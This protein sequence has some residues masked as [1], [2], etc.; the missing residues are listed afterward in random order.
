MQS[1]S[2]A[3]CILILLISTF[4]TV[5]ESAVPT[6]KVNLH[7]SAT[8][9]CYERCSGLVR[10]T[11]SHKPT[12]ALAEC[13]QTSCR[14]VKEGYQMIHD[15]YLKGNLSLIITDADFTKRNMYTCD[16]DGKDLCDVDLQIESLKTTVQIKPGESLVLD[17]EVSDPVEVIY[18]SSDGAKL[19]S[20]QI[21]KVDG[22]SLQCKDEYKQRMSIPST[23]EL[24]GI[25]PSDSG[26]YTIR[27]SRNEEVI[28]TYTVT[29]Q[30]DLPH[31]C[32]DEGTCVPAWTVVV[33]VLVGAGLVI[34]VVVIVRQRRESQRSSRPD[35]S[36]V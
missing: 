24:R 22:H 5:S 25:K 26:V 9:S 3:L 31:P 17:L 20:G 23:V 33:L 15:Q 29:V 16:C 13:D 6:V 2:S 8:L 14:S 11:V 34:S 1:C 32:R 18:E 27:D 21:C 7:D 28:H 35:S 12:D 4:T 19:S 36:G 30:D 10:W